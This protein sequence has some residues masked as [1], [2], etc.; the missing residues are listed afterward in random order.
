L[1]IA[2]AGI[3]F[4]AA[5]LALAEFSARHELERHT[6]LGSLEVSDLLGVVAGAALIAAI[7]SVPRLLPPRQRSAMTVAGVR[8]DAFV[9]RQTR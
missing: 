9:H 2:G 1:T 4:G 5:S 3:A 8:P 7:F 6:G